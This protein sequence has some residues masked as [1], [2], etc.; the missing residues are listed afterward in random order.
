MQGS[1]QKLGARG[2]RRMVVWRKRDFEL[3]VDNVLRYYFHQ[4]LKG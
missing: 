3:G 2:P 1:L 4:E